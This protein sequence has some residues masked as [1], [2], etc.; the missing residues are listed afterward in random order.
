MPPRSDYTPGTPSWVELRTPDG[1]AS[2]AFYQ[3]LFGWETTASGDYTVFTLAEKAVAGLRPD[4]TAPAAWT[5]CICV[6]DA[7]VAARAAPDAGGRVVTDVAEV[8][9][10]ARVAVLADPDGTPFTVWEPAGRSGADVVN[11]PGAFC[12]TELGT[13]DPT[14]AAGFYQT[15]FGWEAESYPLPGGS[16]T[17]WEIGGR[18]VAGMADSST[19][20]TAHSPGWTVYFAV[21]DCDAAVETAQGLGAAVTVPPTDI[22]PGRH[23]IVRDPQGA[24]FA[25]IQLTHEVH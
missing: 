18:V 10:V 4:T 11:E 17:E 1:D 24:R 8:P 15:L 14:E 6:G 19:G 20:G 12:F 7:A 16:Y 9:G 25:L 21:A 3:G 2:A 5:A 13:H 22:P 23:A